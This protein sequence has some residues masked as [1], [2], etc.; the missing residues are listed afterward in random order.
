MSDPRIEE[1]SK[2]SVY[3]TGE[4][5]GAFLTFL[6]RELIGLADAVDPLRGKDSV[7]TIV[8][9]FT[10]RLKPL[11][12]VA[13]RE[14][15][16]KGYTE[17]AP[18]AEYPNALLPEKVCPRCEA[19]PTLGGVSIDP[20]HTYK[21]CINHKSTANPDYPNEGEGWGAC[22]YSL[23]SFAAGLGNGG[24]ENEVGKCNL[25]W[26]VLVEPDKGGDDDRR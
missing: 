8:E 16:G 18:L 24:K 23:W 19:G 26:R 9:E 5:I 7:L 3:L 4:E 11:T 12:K 6:L 15:G 13:C 14:C 22:H 10:E 2:G 1:V 25:V 20:D 17:F 21:F